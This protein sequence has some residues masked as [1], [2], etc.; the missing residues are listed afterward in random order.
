MNVKRGIAEGYGFTNKNILNIKTRV[1][2]RTRIG[3]GGGLLTARGFK[4]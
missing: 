1:K 3:K 2:M 4:S